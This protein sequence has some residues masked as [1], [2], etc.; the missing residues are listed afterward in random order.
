MIIKEVDKV[1][2]CAAERIELPKNIMVNHPR[3]HFLTPKQYLKNVEAGTMPPMK[4]HNILKE[5]AEKAT[6][7]ADQMRFVIWSSEISN[8]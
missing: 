6:D 3:A 8:A 4:N 1:C 5:L 7:P 2:D